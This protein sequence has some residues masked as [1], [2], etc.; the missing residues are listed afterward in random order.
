MQKLKDPRHLQGQ[1][2]EPGAQKVVEEAKKTSKKRWTEEKRQKVSYSDTGK[3]A[4]IRLQNTKIRFCS[5][6][7]A[8]A[9]SKIY[10]TLLSNL[11]TLH[12]FLFK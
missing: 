9:A 1:D 5:K 6:N 7:L 12:F 4:K 3:I 10:P 11:P 2:G 8:L